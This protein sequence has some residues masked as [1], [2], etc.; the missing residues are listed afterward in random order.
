MVTGTRVLLYPKFSIE[1]QK[2]LRLILL[3]REHN[4]ALN[5]EL[6]SQSDLKVALVESG[7]FLDAYGYQYKMVSYSLTPLSSTFCTAL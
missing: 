5:F 1:Y 6:A 7:L 2:V 3:L 4:R